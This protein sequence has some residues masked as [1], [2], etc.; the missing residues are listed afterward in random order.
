M[1]TGE[2]TSDASALKQ[3]AQQIEV[4]IYCI[5][6]PHGSTK[7]SV[8]EE[9][10]RDHQGSQ[11]TCLFVGLRDISAMSELTEMHN[12]CGQ[13]GLT[14]MLQESVTLVSSADSAVSMN[15]S[16]VQERANFDL[17]GIEELMQRGSVTEG[18]PVECGVSSENGRLR[19]RAV[20]MSGGSASRSS[21]SS[22]GSR[23]V[24]EP[25]QEA[26]QSH[27]SV[28][29]WPAWAKPM[30]TELLMQRLFLL[31]PYLPCERGACCLW[32]N[33]LHQMAKALQKVAE[34]G[35]FQG[36]TDV[37]ANVCIPHWEPNTAWQCEVCLGLNCELDEDS[38]EDE[39]TGNLE[40]SLCFAVKPRDLQNGEQ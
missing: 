6:L 26:M 32:H 35:R 22:S 1:G 37:E 24:L 19:G 17:G 18:R 2:V 21:R 40:C 5:C 23:V 10:H 31:L 14:S 4:Q 25:I 27:P 11:D 20:Y 38:D 39:E 7:G 3:S 12:V 30:S 15:E 8:D 29:V 36:N 9:G 34:Q 33:A 16:H 28:G 13:S